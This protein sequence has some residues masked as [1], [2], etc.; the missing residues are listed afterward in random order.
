MAL[1]VSR[2]ILLARVIPDLFPQ[3]DLTRRFLRTIGLG[4]MT[5]RLAQASIMRSLQA[6]G[7]LETSQRNP[8]WCSA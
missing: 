6:L 4:Q 5:L 8:A 2:L 3:V 1:L 7:T